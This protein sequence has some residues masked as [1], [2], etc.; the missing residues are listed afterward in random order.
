MKSAVRQGIQDMVRSLSLLPVS[1]T[2]KTEIY[3]PESQAADCLE[4]LAMFWKCS[5]TPLPSSKDPHFQNE[6]RCTIFLAKMSFICIADHLPSFWNRGPG[7]LGNS[8]LSLLPLLVFRFLVA[9][10]THPSSLLFL[11]S[12]AFSGS[13]HSSSSSSLSPSAFTFVASLLIDRDLPLTLLVLSFLTRWCKWG[14]CS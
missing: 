12:R 11:I 6:A 2:L 4:F 9:L 7:E 14:D 1:A 8:L 3:V 13:R 5:N 10:L